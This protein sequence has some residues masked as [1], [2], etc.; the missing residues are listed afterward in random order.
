[1]YLF[2][3]FDLALLTAFLALPPD[4]SRINDA[5]PITALG[6]SGRATP[7]LVIAK[8]LISIRK[9]L[10]S[11]TTFTA[12]DPVAHIANTLHT[13]LTTIK[14]GHEFHLW[15]RSSTAA[16]LQAI[17]ECVN[18]VTRFLTLH[19]DLHKASS[20]SATS[21]TSSPFS[22]QSHSTISANTLLRRA[23]ATADTLALETCSLHF[24]S[25]GRRAGLLLF[26][27]VDATIDREM[28]TKD[29][30]LDLQY[31]KSCFEGVRVG[32]REWR[33]E[34][35]VVVFGDTVAWLEQ[36]IMVLV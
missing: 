18:R 10:A 17:H 19:P 12:I 22:P 1:V 20:T 30:L 3:Y 7:D 32:A 6:D 28:D 11:A 36:E 14:H 31:W 15:P 13:S 29:D 26:G 9:A 4:Y 34:V 27:N 23:F 8:A 16:A 25:G 5:A 24:A 21:S 2:T 33:D 35:G